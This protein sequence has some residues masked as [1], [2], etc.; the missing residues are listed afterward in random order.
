VMDLAST[1]LFLVVYLATD[2]LYVAVGLGMHWAWRRS[3]GHCRAA[4]RWAA[5][6][7]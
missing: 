4:S 5:C 1:I 2:N 7:S 3:A 6:R